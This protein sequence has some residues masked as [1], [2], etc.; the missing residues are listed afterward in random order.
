MDLQRKVRQVYVDAANTDENMH[1]VDCS[2]PQ[3]EMASPEVIFERVMER[4]NPYIK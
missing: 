1:I 3:G 2:T 4:V